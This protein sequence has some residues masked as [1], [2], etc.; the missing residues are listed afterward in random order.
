MI[1][2]LGVAVFVSDA[3]VG[4]LHGRYFDARQVGNLRSALWFAALLDVAIGLNLLGFVEA[5]AWMLLPSVLGGML[6][7]YWSMR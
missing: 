3:C 4:Y 6:G 2:A 7:T 1:I 5:K